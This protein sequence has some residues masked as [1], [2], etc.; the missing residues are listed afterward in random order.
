MK[1]S[2]FKMD[3]GDNIWTFCTF[4]FLFYFFGLF[5]FIC[6]SLKPTDTFSEFVSQTS[7]MKGCVWV[8]GRV[9][10]EWFFFCRILFHYL[11][12]WCEC[13]W[14]RLCNR[15]KAVSA[16]FQGWTWWTRATSWFCDSVIW[17]RALIWSECAQL[18]KD[19]KQAHPFFFFFSAWSEPQQALQ[20]PCRSSRLELFL[21]VLPFAP[22]CS[23][24]DCCYCLLLDSS[25]RATPG[26]C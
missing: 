25:N 24:S 16:A 3:A 5:T 1:I 12:R 7:W 2:S 4:F 19:I 11:R 17:Q 23:R 13:V 21:L 20:P 26:S 9:T 6:K 15:L 18:F 10:A 14:T 22:S 8:E